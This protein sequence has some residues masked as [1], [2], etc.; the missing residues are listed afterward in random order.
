MSLKGKTIAF[1]GGGH[2]TE[3]IIDNLTQ[4]KTISADQMIV[5][6]PDPKRREHLEQTF[7]VKTTSDNKKAAEDSDI[8]FINVRPQVI[9]EIIEEFS[10]V[11]L[12]AGKV[13][14]TLAAGIPMEKYRTLGQK[15]AIVRA[16]PNPPSQVGLGIIALAFNEYVSTFMQKDILNL[17]DSMGEVVI[18]KEEHINTTMALSSPTSVLLFF[19]SLIDAGVK[20]GMDRDTSTKIASQT[21]IGVMEVWKHRQV[22]LETLLDE[23]CTPGGISKESLTILDNYNFKEAISEAIRKAV[24]KA[25]KLGRSIDDKE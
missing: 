17:F 10:R 20:M 4:S 3:I 1:I 12:Q 8:V 6:D 23:A 24:I 18:L 16:L 11:S 25:E 2:I 5:S 7:S 14:V 15:L 9:G 19:K 21:I 22:S 13:V